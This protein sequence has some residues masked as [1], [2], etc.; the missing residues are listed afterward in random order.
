MKNLSPKI[1]EQISKALKRPEGTMT[2]TYTAEVDLYDPNIPGG[3]I[4]EVPSGGHYFRLERTNNAEIHFYYS[5]PGTGTRVAVVDLKEMKPSKKTF[6]GFSWSPGEINLHVGPKINGATL[7]SA[8]GT[9]SSK[10]FRVA[11]DG[12]IIQVGDV[13]GNQVMGLRATLGGKTILESTALG[14]WNETKEIIKILHSGESKQGYIFDMIIANLTFPLMVT[15]FEVYTKRRFTEL[16]EEGIVPDFAKIFEKMRPSKKYSNSEE[17]L[18][19][20]N[21]QD[22]K[23][24]CKSIYFHGYNIRFHE[25]GIKGEDFRKL[26]MIFNYRGRITHNS[27]LLSMLNE[28]IVPQ[29]DPVFNSKSQALEHL[30]ILDNFIQELHKKTLSLKKGDFK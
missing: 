14:S 16:E 1:L 29:Q 5:S 22:F 11:K 13:V 21:F 23:N 4:F 30:D 25:L 18:N 3:I 15:G 20:I 12:G 28:S 19:T 26:E 24:E 8:K 2:F 27:S 9:P 7:V 17:M 10:T 6:F